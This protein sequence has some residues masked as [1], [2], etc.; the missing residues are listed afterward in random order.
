MKSFGEYREKSI[1]EEGLAP[2]LKQLLACFDKA[3]A[4]ADKDGMEQTLVAIEDA[5]QVI[6]SLAGK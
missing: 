1:I 5:R 3:S 4:I 6:I 2:E